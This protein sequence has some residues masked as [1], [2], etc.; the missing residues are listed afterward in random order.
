[1]PDVS[2][3]HMLPPE[4]YPFTMRAF[5]ERTGRELWSRVVEAPD[6]LYAARVPPLA[7][8]HGEPVRIR[9]E[10]ADGSVEDG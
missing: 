6:G 2:G 4:L 1:M 5:G 9:I 7:R 8:M 3:P 10:F